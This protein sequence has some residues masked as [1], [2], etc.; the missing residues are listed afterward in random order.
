MRGAVDEAGPVVVED[1]A[2]SGGRVASSNLVLTFLV[3]LIKK[4]KHYEAFSFLD[5]P[6][7]NLLRQTSVL[8]W[9]LG[10]G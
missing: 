2:E 1:G 8:T 9:C 7:H 4:N 5:I 10:A 6:S 3:D